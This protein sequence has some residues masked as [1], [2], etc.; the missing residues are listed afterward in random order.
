MYTLRKIL[1]ECKF[2]KRSKETINIIIHK[3]ILY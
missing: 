3:Y 1:R 2:I